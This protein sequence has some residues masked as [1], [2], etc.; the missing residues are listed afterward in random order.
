[1]GDPIDDG[2]IEDELNQLE[3]EQNEQ[4]MLDMPAVSKNP[5]PKK[6]EP[7]QPVAATAV[8]AKAKP[9]SE[10]DDDLAAL[11]AELNS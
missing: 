2:D 4:D 10:E 11:E 7:K 8:K 9:K 6:N 5:L 1:M 3:M